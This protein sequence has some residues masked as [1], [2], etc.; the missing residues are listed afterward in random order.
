MAEESP[1]RK[2][3]PTRTINI[4][5]TI[6]NAPMQDEGVD[7]IVESAKRGKGRPVKQ[8]PP[9]PDPVA[10]A[11]D[12]DADQFHRFLQDGT[13][14]VHVDR[15]SPR[16]WKG[17]PISGM[18]DEYVTPITQDEIEADLRQRFGGGRYRIRVIRH[19]K[20]IAARGVSVYGDPKIDEPEDEE[21]DG[22]D[23]DRMP[24]FRN[25]PPGPPMQ[26]DE[27]TNLRVQIE[28]EK[29]K[30]ALEEVKGTSKPSSTAIDPMRIARETEDR[31][32][33]EMETKS[34]IQNIKVEL[35]QK[36]SE[37]VNTIT[38][39]L[40]AQKETDPG[41]QSDIVAMDN[42]IERI[43]TEVTAEVKS[44][45][46]EIRSLLTSANKPDNSAAMMTAMIQ[47]MAQMAQSGKSE[48]AAI[49]Q[50][51]TAKSN[52]QMQALKE[53]NDAN[54]RV[55]QAQTDKLVAVMQTNNKND[56]G[57]IKGVAET[58]AAVR[59]IAESMGMGNNGQPEEAEPQSLT[60]RF[61][62]MLEKAMP[63]VLAT[64]KQQSDQARA[65]GVPLTQ[66][67][68]NEI[69]RQEAVKQARVIAPQV[70]QQM[71]QRAQGIPQ[72]PPPQALPAPQQQPQV[73]QQPPRP[74]QNANPG[75]PMGPR[76]INVE[77]NHQ[78]PQQPQQPMPQQVQPPVQQPPV[79]KQQ[80]AP[81][82]PIVAQKTDIVNGCMELLVSEIK[83]RPRAQSWCDAAYDDL[84]EDILE[85]L[86]IATDIDGVLAAISPFCDQQYIEELKNVLASE[87][88]AVEWL[89]KGLNILKDLYTHGDEEEEGDAS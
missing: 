11:E 79:E 26:T 73:Q 14:K 53:I 84:P 74:Q 68:I 58:I 87:P 85:K 51:E 57:G 46:A 36:L 56:S 44:N 27:L 17:K 39:T 43:K 70:A 35:N 88:R 65:A 1:L 40:K 23:F 12:D 89:V 52:A 41:R 50:A 5:E 16:E 64:I 42:K 19:G 45:F 80:E 82:D 2:K 59:D 22:L 72:Q 30:N 9:P 29:L 4:Q 86:A 76:P 28:K 25:V 77:A 49:M 31:V 63:T 62:G 61:V 3:E 33:K 13:V 75:V 47:G 66:Q 83:L 48:L 21:D 8:P 18:I 38:N 34:E 71:A 78:Q 24:D 10:E 20:F 55:A 15:V 81:V 6:A 54:A 60:E 69:Y 67:Q 7:E 32:R 37:F